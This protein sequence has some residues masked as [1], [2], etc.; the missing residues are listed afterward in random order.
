MLAG[1]FDLGDLLGSDRAE[2]RVG[3]HVGYVVGVK[4]SMFH[5]MKAR[6]IE[7][8]GASNSTSASLSQIMW[9]CLKTESL[10]NS[11]AKARIELFSPSLDQADLKAGE[12]LQMV[13]STPAFKFGKLSIK[14]VKRRAILA[15]QLLV[16][17]TNTVSPEV[18][19]NQSIV[20]EGV[21]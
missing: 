13:W 3:G 18:E 17:V 14:T 4:R 8:P 1:L 2:V 9:S 21:P 5:W 12:A 20:T 11:S 15:P 6:R 16:A 10:K 7:Q 19:G